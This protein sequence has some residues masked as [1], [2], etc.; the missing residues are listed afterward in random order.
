MEPRCSRNFLAV[1]KVRQIFTGFSGPA[2]AATA[3]KNA[4]GCGSSGGAVGVPVL[5]A[6]VEQTKKAEA[7][8]LSG[9]NL[10]LARCLWDA[11]RQQSWISMVANKIQAKLAAIKVSFLVNSHLN[12]VFS[13]CLNGKDCNHI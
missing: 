3:Q 11:M 1:T 7:W 4:E 9:V 5:K 12:P 8:P 13:Q 10:L 2:T 6:Q